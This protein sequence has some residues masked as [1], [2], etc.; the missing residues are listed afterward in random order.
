MFKIAILAI[1]AALG[2][3][4]NIESKFWKNDN[5]CDQCDSDK[6]FA[7]VAADRVKNEAESDGQS[8]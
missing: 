2:S 3:A 7:E 6:L 1:I 8:L 4:V 5:D